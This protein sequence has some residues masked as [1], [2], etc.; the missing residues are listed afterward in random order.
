M[1]GVTA[2][3]VES[4]SNV[5]SARESSPALA[6]TLTR[7]SLDFEVGSNKPVEELG[8]KRGTKREKVT[9]S[10]RSISRRATFSR[11][12]FNPGLWPR[13]VSA[14]VSRIALCQRIT[15]WGLSITAL[16]YVVYN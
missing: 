2:D 9:L 6:R 8:T 12:G 14:I 5:P 10:Q 4:E 11:N 7:W 3:G 13:T 1:V 15:S 16:Q